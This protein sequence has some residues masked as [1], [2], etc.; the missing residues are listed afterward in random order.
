MAQCTEAL[1][2]HDASL[3]TLTTEV[4]SCQSISSLSEN[5]KC[6]A[7]SLSPEYSA[8]VMRQ[9]ILYPRGG[10]QPSDTG[11]LA[12]EDQE[13]TFTVLLVRKTQD[14]R[15]LHFGKPDNTDTIFV[16][17]QR[18]IQNVDGDR[19][20]Y[21]SRLHTGGHIVGLAMELLFPD[22]KKVKAN[23]APGE[24][25]MEYEGLLYNEQKLLIQAKVDELVKQD[26]PILISWVED[27]SDLEGRGKIA[28]AQF[29]SQVLVDLIRILAVV[30]MSTGPVWLGLS[31]FAKSVDK[32]GLA[33]SRT[34][35]LR[36]NR[37]VA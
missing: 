23:H 33:G 10:G 15:I 11:T 36:S 9:T 25:C 29:E 26:L 18:V 20:D 7:K 19:R 35:F 16:E 34:K 32:K 22:M 6:L 13:P 5:E 37:L 21:H 28:K 30:P 27:G 17:G 2:L 8:I 14:G 4:I 31:L 1:Y 12:L 3:R 24:A